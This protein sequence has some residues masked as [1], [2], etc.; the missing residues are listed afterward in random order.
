MK[1][2]PVK[3]NV[4]RFT[5]TQ[6]KNPLVNSL[7]AQK[8]PEASNCKYLRIILRSNLNC[9]EQVNFTSQKKAWKALHF[10]MYVVKKG[11]RNKQ[12]LDYTSLVRPIHEYGFAYWDLCRGQI[13]ASDRVQKKV[14]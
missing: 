7:G 9:V 6:V 13:N 4:L 10:A 11:N 2:Y 1:T 5:R 14:V 12:S 8:F 3:S